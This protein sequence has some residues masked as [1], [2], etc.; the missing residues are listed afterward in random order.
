MRTLWC[1][2]LLLVVVVTATSDSDT[3]F[4]TSWHGWFTEDAPAWDSDLNC[5][6]NAD[7]QQCAETHAQLDELDHYRI[8]SSPYDA[9]FD[10][11]IFHV[12]NAGVEKRPVVQNDAFSNSSSLEMFWPG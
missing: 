11:T 6:L 2:V 3:N 12:L 7:Q 4:D 5:F 9:F 10:G 8:Q 1:A